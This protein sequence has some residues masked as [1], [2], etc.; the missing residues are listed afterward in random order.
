M[1]YAPL[2]AALAWLLGLTVIGLPVAI[3]MFNRTPFI[4]SLYWY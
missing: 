4:A 2:P 1:I 3:L